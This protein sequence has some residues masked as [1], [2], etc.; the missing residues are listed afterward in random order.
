MF[1]SLPWC[2]G[3]ML[4]WARPLCSR[5]GVHAATAPTVPHFHFQG[6]PAYQACWVSP[7]STCLHGTIALFCLLSPNLIYWSTVP[8]LVS[9]TSVSQHSKWHP[10]CSKGDGSEAPSTVLHLCLGT[11]KGT[12]RRT[13]PLSA[14]P[15]FACWS[16]T[17]CLAL[18]TPNLSLGV[19]HVLQKTHHSV[20][21]RPPTP[22]GNIYKASEY[23][24]GD[25]MSVFLRLLS[26]FQVESSHF[27]NLSSDDK[28]SK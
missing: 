23:V 9:P 21:P 22:S 15:A 19:L 11:L 1:E 4:K 2:L 13:G 28:I 7:T 5:E 27:L 16:H 25:A 12:S 3:Q 18:Q 24:H 8:S 17:V 26:V 14:V 6:W 20:P 10:H